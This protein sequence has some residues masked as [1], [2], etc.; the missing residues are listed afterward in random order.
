MGEG[1]IV[2]LIV[3]EDDRRVEG[4]EVLFSGLWEV[5][6]VIVVDGIYSFVG[7]EFGG[8]YIVIFILDEN[9][10]NGVFIFDLIVISKYILGE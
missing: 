3:M 2:G 4:V 5:V 10:L 8:D 9:Y 7:L 6:Y 1:I